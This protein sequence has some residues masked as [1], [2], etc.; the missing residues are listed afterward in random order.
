MRNTEKLGVKLAIIADDSVEN[1]E[2]LIMTDDGTGH[3]INIPSFIIS[4]RNADTLK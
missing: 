2:S 1:T 3:S 4:K